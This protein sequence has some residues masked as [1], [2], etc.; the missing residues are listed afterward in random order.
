MAISTGAAL[1]G[2]A[3]IGAGSSAMGASKAAS[4]TK[5]AANTAAAAERYQY[6]TTR[7]DFRPYRE[8]GGGA[9]NL[10]ADIYG[11]SRSEMTPAPAPVTTLP[12]P[13]ATGP[14]DRTGGFYESPGFRFRLNEGNKA[15]ERGAA[16]RG[17]LFSGGAVKAAS[18]YTQGTASDEFERYVAGLRSLSGVG[19]T[20]TGSTAA[21]GANAANGISNAAL[22]G[23]AG[24]AS[25]YMAGATGINNAVQGGISNYMLSK[26]L[27]P[28]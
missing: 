1:V 20:A 18:D 26:Y 19:Q 17:R 27:N 21:A 22:A 13:A 12:R 7:E 15:I 9:L 25:A 16:A 6:D 28:A 10:L 24:R 3:V 5:S 2:A 11:V 4:A 8:V 14:V 23:G